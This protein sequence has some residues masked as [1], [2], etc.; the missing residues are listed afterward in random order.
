MCHINFAVRTR[1]K[2][3]HGKLS[4]VSWAAI[5]NQATNQSGINYVN[6]TKR[7]PLFQQ[8]QEGSKGML[9]SLSRYAS[10]W[11]NKFT[12]LFAAFSTIGEPLFVIWHTILGH[13]RKGCCSKL[14][15][16]IA[17]VGRLRPPKPAGR[18][19]HNRSRTKNNLPSLYAN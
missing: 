8:L 13:H 2:R 17:L 10:A 19:F 7:L 12:T 5:A 15:R 9:M 14:T 1:I 18:K 3:Y 11:C 4:C 16:V 6:K